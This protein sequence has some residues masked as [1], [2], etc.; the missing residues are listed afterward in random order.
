MC[1]STLSL[2]SAL[3]GV[4]GQRHAPATLPPGKTRFPL[5]KMLRGPQGRSGRERKIL[6]QTGLDPR[7]VQPV[8]SRHTGCTRQYSW[9]SLGIYILWTTRQTS[10]HS[11]NYSNQ[12]IRLR[13][14]FKFP[15]SHNL[16]DWKYS[17]TYRLIP[18]VFRGWL[19]N[20]VPSRTSL[21][22]SQPASQTPAG[23]IIQKSD[24]LW[25]C[26]SKYK[27]W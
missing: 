14:A 26:P 15:Q 24:K 25:P 16:N 9:N 20:A 13:P 5:Y 19:T 1:S 22:I 10:G 27:M 11:L 12:N 21:Y 23:L 2:T 4:G 7:T 17:S 8:V 18:V 3:D 6:P